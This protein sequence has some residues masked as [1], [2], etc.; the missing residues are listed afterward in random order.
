VKQVLL[1]WDLILCCFWM[2]QFPGER[3]RDLPIVE[4]EGM[5]RIS[6][7]QEWGIIACLHGAP[8]QLHFSEQQPA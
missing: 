8:C 7:I 5:Q 4:P 2:I 6:V 3:N 1:R